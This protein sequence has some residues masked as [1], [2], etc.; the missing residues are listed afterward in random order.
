VDSLSHGPLLKP[1]AV[2][3]LPNELSPHAAFVSFFF[4]YTLHKPFYS[5]NVCILDDKMRPA[6][7]TRFSPSRLC[8][9]CT[10]GPAS[11]SITTTTRRPFASTP[12]NLA[13]WGFIGLG[14]MGELHAFY[15][16]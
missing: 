10:N 3:G 2:E 6:I 8:T 16:A 11:T 15:R 4:K 1:P 9:L 5:A 14:R 7:S 13:T 12:S